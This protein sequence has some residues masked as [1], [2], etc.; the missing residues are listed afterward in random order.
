MLH[1][2]PDLG[3]RSIRLPGANGDEIEAYEAMPEGTL[4][5]G[6]VVVV[7][8]MHGL[9]RATKEIVRRFAEMGYHAICPNLY[10]RDAPGAPHDEALRKARAN[11]GV[12]NERVIGDVLGARDHLLA[13]E[14]SNG[15]VGIIGYASGGR[16]AVLAA[17]HG[18]FDAVID[19]YGAYVTGPVPEGRPF[20]EN[21]VGIL[22]NLTGSFLGLFCEHDKSPTA[23]DIRELD[24][25]LTQQGTPHT[26]HT[27]EAAHAFFAVDLPGYNVEAANDG[28]DRI[29]EFLGATVGRP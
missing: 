7:H 2:T 15:K 28:W 16:H 11:G 9:D 26:M 5:R 1:P 12:A 29:D 19:C 8:H 25:L 3:A 21:L 20:T 10:W 4:P 13:A 22:P 17:C 27:Y 14:S 6:G 24:D 23:D 18:A